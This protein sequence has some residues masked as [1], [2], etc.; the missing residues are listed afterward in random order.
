MA[1]L[2][3][4]TM[5]TDYVS[6][7][8]TV[9]DLAA[10]FPN[11]VAGDKSAATWPYFRKEIGH[12]WYVDRR[13]PQIGF[14]N[15]DEAA[16]LYSSAK[17]FSGK[18]G[19]EIGAWRGWSSSHLLASG[20][21]SLHIIE[22]QLA[23]PEWRSEFAA[24]LQQAGDGDRAILV[25]GFSPDEVV[26][27]GEAGWRWSFAFIDGNHDGDAPKTD[28]LTA[29]KYLEPTSLVLFHDLVSPYVAAGLDALKA[30][31]WRTMIYQTAQIMGVAW[32]GDIAPVRHK[33]DP[34]QAWG[35]PD[36]LDGYEIS[37]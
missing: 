18:K 9:P 16:I 23:E 1:A 26:S 31:G 22:P 20:L 37:S 3:L 30:R 12:T 14:V 8:L 36:H 5:S 28:T 33:P 24:T 25:P 17:L 32:R 35:L 27:L 29:E 13:H 7:N 19:L 21:A 6:E 34:A 2:E 11:M 10:Y 4:K 15:K